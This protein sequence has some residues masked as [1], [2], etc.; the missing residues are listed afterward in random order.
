[1]GVSLHLVRGVGY[2]M[3]RGRLGDGVGSG[4]T[5]LM[6]VLSS[7]YTHLHLIAYTRP[8]LDVP[9]FTII[10]TIRLVLDTHCETWNRL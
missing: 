10:V 9:S 4:M 1:M 2:R 3:T 5:V 6:I 7:P 8:P